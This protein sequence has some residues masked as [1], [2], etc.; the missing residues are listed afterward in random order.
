MFLKDNE[1]IKSIIYTFF[2]AKKVCKK[3]R[4]FGYLGIGIVLRVSL[5]NLKNPDATLN[6]KG[7]IMQLYCPLLNLVMP[8]VNYSRC[9]IRARQWDASKF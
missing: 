5:Y 6:I 1:N 7:G 2:S 9:G 3:T 8:H 4:R